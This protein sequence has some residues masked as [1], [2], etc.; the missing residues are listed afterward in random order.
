MS[1]FGEIIYFTLLLVLSVALTFLNFL[2]HCCSETILVGKPRKRALTSKQNFTSYLPSLSQQQFQSTSSNRS[3][4]IFEATTAP[5]I[6]TPHSILDPK[7]SYLIPCFVARN[8]DCHLMQS[9]QRTSRNWGECD[10]STALAHLK[11]L[12]CK[13]FGITNKC[14]RYFINED[15]QYYISNIE[16]HN[17]VHREAV[18]SEW[19][20]SNC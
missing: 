2:T 11:M 19:C 6:L 20:L 5:F 17:E 7:D 3:L 1:K 15:G 10:Q 18:Q 4:A 16:R 13:L 14:L 9:T 12:K 8:K